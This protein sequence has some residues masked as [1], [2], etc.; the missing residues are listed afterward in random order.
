MK[1]LVTFDTPP[2]ECTL[3]PGETARMH[4]DIA[5]AITPAEYEALMAAGWRHFGHSL[6]TPRCPHCSACQSLRI[7]VNTFAPNRSQK[8]ALAANADVSLT[9]HEPG[10]TQE[11]L[12]LYNRFHEAQSERVGWPDKETIDPAE[13]AESFVIQPFRVEEWQYRI[14]GRLVGVGY[15]DPLP[16]SLSAIYFYHEPEE[17]QRSLG[18]FNV[19]S[20]I[21]SAKR[22]GL[23]H[24]YLGYYV[25]GCRSLEYKARFTPNEI[26][27]NDGWRQGFS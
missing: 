15:V 27:E 14:E 18:T 2:K 21:E 1:S 13:Y 5:A 8:R 26:L 19:L 4:Y 22:R 24:A 11:K 25:E 12:S 3:L 6:F 10:V 23:E 9:I 17:R 20:V 16:R 7:P